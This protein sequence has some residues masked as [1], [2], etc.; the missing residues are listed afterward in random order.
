[1]VDQT[2]FTTVQS[3]DEVIRQL[4]LKDELRKTE[5]NT[6]ILG[7]SV[8]IPFSDEVLDGTIHLYVERIRGPEV[9]QHPNGDHVFETLA[10]VEPNGEPFEISLTPPLGT[11]HYEGALATVSE[12][13]QRIIMEYLDRDDRIA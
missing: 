12:E 7:L 8:S 2:R 11:S 6:F 13:M 5:G 4:Y 10:R 9:Y 3:G 1:M